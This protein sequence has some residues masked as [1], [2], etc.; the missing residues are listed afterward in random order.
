MFRQFPFSS[1][2][3]TVTQLENLKKHHEKDTVYFDRQR[4]HQKPRLQQSKRPRFMYSKK[5]CKKL[6]AQGSRLSFSFKSDFIV[7]L[8]PVRITLFGKV[9]KRYENTKKKYFQTKPRTE[10]STTMGPKKQNS[11]SP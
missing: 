1:Q 8:Q 7:N 10:N 9:C 11:I 6:K 4:A 5:H 3:V 2:P